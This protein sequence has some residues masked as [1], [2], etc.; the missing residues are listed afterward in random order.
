MKKETNVTTKGVILAGGLGTR[1]HPLTS[2]VS[3]QLL[4]VYNKPMIFYPL[5]VLVDAGINDIMIITTKEHEENFKKLLGYGEE[6]SVK[7]TYKIQDKPEGI[8]QSLI[9]SEKWSKDSQIVLILGD[10]LFFGPNLNQTVKDGI[11]NNSGATIFC[12]ESKN[13]ERFGVIEFD[14]KFKAIS[15][16]EKPKKPKTNWV[17]TGLYIYNNQAPK[18]AKS[19]KKSKRGEYEITDFNN[20]YLLNNKLN[21]KKLGGDFSWLDTGTF[22]SLL[23][24]SNYV[25]ELE[26]K[27]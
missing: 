11:E 15:I 21:V 17:V 13:P 6:W 3:K 9:L 19:L 24:A 20:L 22:D 23:E 16:D 18:Y 2:I 10:N 4:P 7:L 1:L 12:I 8:A 5:S 26:N 27:K 14:K 25:K